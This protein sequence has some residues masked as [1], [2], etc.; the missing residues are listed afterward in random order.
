[1]RWGG[2]DGGPV[3]F[4]LDSLCRC[5]NQ[6][7]RKPRTQEAKGGALTDRMARIA[8]RRTVKQ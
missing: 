1:M 2:G 4:L 5:V 8:E 3:R 6:S 7:A